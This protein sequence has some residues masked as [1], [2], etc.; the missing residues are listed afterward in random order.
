M[1]LVQNNMGGKEGNEE[2]EAK[3]LFG[4]IENLREQF[5]EGTAEPS[6]EQVAEFMM[7]WLA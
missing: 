6:V 3:L 1:A 5:P 2:N 4:L 7:N